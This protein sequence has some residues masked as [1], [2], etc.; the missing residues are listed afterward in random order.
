MLSLSGSIKELRVIISLFLIY[1]AILSFS[2]N[3]FTVHG[4]KTGDVVLWSKT[5]SVGYATFVSQ[6][7]AGDFVVGSSNILV[8]L[9]ETG[10]LI[11]GKQYNTLG[12]HQGPVLSS[13]GGG[14]LIAQGA[15]LNDPARILKLDKNGDIVW[16]HG[17]GAGFF[18]GVSLSIFSAVETPDK[19]FAIAGEIPGSGAFVMKIDRIGNVVWTNV[20]GYFGC[21]RFYSLV[22]SQDGEFVAAGILCEHAW[23]V[24][25]DASGA[26]V[27]Q[28]QYQSGDV[29]TQDI[30]AVRVIATSDSGFL[31]TGTARRV[32]VQPWVLKIDGQGTILWQKFYNGFQGGFGDAVETSDGGTVILGD[33]RIIKLDAAGNEE[34]HHGFGNNTFHGSL[35]T[36]IDTRDGGF[37]LGGTTGTLAEGLSSW[38]LKLNS[39]GFCCDNMTGAGSVSGLNATTIGQESSA[40]VSTEAVNVTGSD[41]VAIDIAVPVS[42]QCPP[43]FQSPVRD[44]DDTAQSS[45]QT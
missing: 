31:V 15:G 43:V 7:K 21:G 45:N 26:I 36:I 19:N 20:Y 17:Y 23:V 22:T 12:G 18:Q 3:S 5:Y 34:W 39:T 8:K 4:V 42:V 14:Y 16:Q 44:G 35:S 2:S 13:S 29:I 1:I 33:A 30:Q 40:T 11:W 37:I 27:W 32:S 28:R 10:E 41:N 25:L 38:I 9:S 6:T 24:K